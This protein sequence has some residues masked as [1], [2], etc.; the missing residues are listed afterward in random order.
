MNIID[1]FKRHILIRKTSKKLEKD[2]WLKT[3]LMMVWDATNDLKKIDGNK[4]CDEPFLPTL[5]DSSEKIKKEFS[6]DLIRNL[7]FIANSEDRVLACRNW[8][9][10]LVDEYSPIV[11][12]LITKHDFDH[13][14]L[15]ES[16]CEFS[17]LII[18]NSFHELYLQAVGDINLCKDY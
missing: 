10:G 6:E 12:F 8:I 18:K 3:V 11:T 7:N 2:E 16:L 14:C 4:L 15:Q 9:V 17:D 13:P 1:R 5:L